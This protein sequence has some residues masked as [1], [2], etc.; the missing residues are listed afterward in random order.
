MDLLVVVVGLLAV[1]GILYI[2]SHNWRRTVKA[3]LVLV[4]IEGAL[5]K[6]VL[7]Q[8]SDFMYFLKDLVLLGA[9]LKYFAFARSEKK[10]PVRN[11]LLNN[12][13]VI[14]AGWCLFQAFNPS[15][16]SPVVGLFGSRGY[17]FYI[18][19]MWMLPNL[20]QSES[21]L[22]KF[23]RSH[24]LLVIPVGI[25]GIAQ[26]F[27]PA[28]SP[29]NV[30]APG[31]VSSVATFG[32]TNAVRVTGTFSYLS[33]FSVYLA[34]C[35]GLLIPMLTIKQSQWWR[36]VTVAELLLVTVNSFMT[37]SRGVVITE[38]LF[39]LGYLGIQGITRP[40]STVRLLGKFIAPVT[41]VAIAA[42]IWFQSAIDAFWRRTTGNQDLSGRI[43]GSF[44]EPFEFIQY[45]ELDGYGTG[46]THQ[47]APALRRV[48]GLPGG[49]FIPVGYESEM[50]RVALELGPLGFLLWYC[51]R[52]SLIIALWLVFW[53]L[54]R[55]FLRQLALVAFLIEAIQIN[56]QLVT[57][58]T[59]SVY[60]WF[61]NGFIFLL[62]RLEQIE[63]W[64]QEQLMQEYAESAYFP[65]SPHE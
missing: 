62:P 61:L 17:I 59:F 60:Y 22:Y 46:A 10:Y 4:V 38:V 7:P 31:E 26:F 20:F 44:M 24:L 56:G 45:K 32:A 50:G 25:L 41:V 14:V 27:S 6:W 48:L 21:E 42:C 19:L 35:F 43:A 13:I 49:E 28:S 51:L 16:G 30:Y 36:W 33:G 57:H 47:A 39:L 40:A 55:P 8:A 37:G 3:V 11:N 58:H 5:R 1:A 54:K 65:D 2:S 34:V 12:L 29:L 53:K 18:P 52:L 23:L 9:Y 15:L 64:Q 63:N